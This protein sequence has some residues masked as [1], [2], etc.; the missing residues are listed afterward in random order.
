MLAQA[1]AAGVAAGRVGA[2]AQAHLLEQ[3]LEVAGPL[4]RSSE[5][6]FSESVYMQSTAAQPLKR[7]AQC[8]NVYCL[9]PDPL[10]RV[11]AGCFFSTLLCCTWQQTQA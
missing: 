2:A 4:D 9:A 3:V 7:R 11:A 10:R 8:L 1:I 6:N 5:S